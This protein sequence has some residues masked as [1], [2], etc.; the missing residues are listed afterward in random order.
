MTRIQVSHLMGSMLL[1][2]KLE[3]KILRYLTEGCTKRL[4]HNQSYLVTIP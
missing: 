3:N 1:V 4:C 2:N